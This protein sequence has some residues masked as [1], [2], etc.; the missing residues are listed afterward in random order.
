MGNATVALSI[1]QLFAV[2]Q[3]A[4]LPPAALAQL[5]AWLGTIR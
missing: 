1:D 3:D 4:V 5:R 2:M